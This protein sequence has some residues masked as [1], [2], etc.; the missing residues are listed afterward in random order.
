MRRFPSTPPELDPVDAPV[1]LD[2]ARL[3]ALVAEVRRRM[4]EE[5]VLPAATYAELADALGSELPRSGA[6]F[7]A[8]LREVEEVAVAYARH[9]A[10]PGFFGYVCSPGLPTDPPAHA[11]AAALNQNL[12]GFSSAPGAT[13]IERA[14]LGWLAALAGLGEEADGLFVS[15]GSLANLTALGAALHRCAGP[16]LRRTGLAGAAQRFTLYVSEATHFSVERAAVLLGVGTQ[17]VRKLPV[18]EQQRLV[19]GLLDEALEEDRKAGARPFC[20][21]GS[22]GTTTTGAIDPL[23]E[24]AAVC[25]RHGVWLHVDAAYGGAALMAP[26]LAPRFAG[27]ERADSLALDLHKWFYLAFDGSAL[28]FRDP[29][30]A[31]R[32]FY[33]RSDY[34]QIPEKPPAEQFAFFHYG[35][36]VSRRFRALPAFIALRHYGA[37]RLGRLVLHNVRC[38]EYLAGLVQRHDELELVAAP[39]LSICCFR[40]APPALRAGERRIDELNRAIRDRLQKE[41]EFYL[42]A[43]DLDGRPVLRVCILSHTTG[44][45][46]VEAL[47]QAVARIGRELIASAS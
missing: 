2:T 8:V 4:E 22:A 19:P 45:R 26:E 17:N 14:V 29:E 41:G 23:D 34:V 16:E 32:L 24:L 40:F 30:P 3:H 21:V 39:Q 27:I 36:E 25:R 38:A 47:T 10:A 15:G 9:N 37:D 5:P 33:A 35:V 18:D 1:E 28:L 13:A 46:H 7:E 11:L 44:A 31:R 20:V 42:S 6:P 12:T 43:T